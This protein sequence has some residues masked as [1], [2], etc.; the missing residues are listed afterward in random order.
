LLAA[1]AGDDDIARSIGVGDAIATAL[2][3]RAWLSKVSSFANSSN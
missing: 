3:R 1:D 2:R